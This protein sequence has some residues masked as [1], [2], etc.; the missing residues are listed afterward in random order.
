MSRHESAEI[1]S[2]EESWT[3]LSHASAM[4]GAASGIG[5][6]KLHDNLVPY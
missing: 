6:V 4:D 3:N 2:Y 5:N 1:G